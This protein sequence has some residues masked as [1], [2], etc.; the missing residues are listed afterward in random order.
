MLFI[1]FQLNTSAHSWNYMSKCHRISWEGH[2]VGSTVGDSL[3][4]LPLTLRYLCSALHKR[5]FISPSKETGVLCS[6]VPHKK[7]GVAQ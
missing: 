3:L 6:R 2:D 1:Q 7:L 4:A 5:S